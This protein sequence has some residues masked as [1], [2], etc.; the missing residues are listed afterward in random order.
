[1]EATVSNQSPLDI[2]R[3]ER[4]GVLWVESAPTLEDA[5][6]RI[7]QLADRESGSYLVLNQRT[8]DKFVFN[9]GCTSAESVR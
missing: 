5:K 4:H 3:V 7:Q 8:G 1:M 6:A 9:P 2:F